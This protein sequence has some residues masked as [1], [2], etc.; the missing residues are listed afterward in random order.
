MRKRIQSWHRKTYWYDESA[1]AQTR[2]HR[3]TQL[4]EL[5]CYTLMIQVSLLA[6]ENKAGEARKVATFSQRQLPL[7]TKAVKLKF[8]NQ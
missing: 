2:T 3:Q 1:H 5:N 6:K 8:F 4:I 7:W